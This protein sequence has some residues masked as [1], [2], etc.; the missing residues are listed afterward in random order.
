MS[1]GGAGMEYRKIPAKYNS[2]QQS[3]LS[4]TLERGSN[5]KDIQLTDKEE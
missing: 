4:V 1:V 3:G 5:T 2:A